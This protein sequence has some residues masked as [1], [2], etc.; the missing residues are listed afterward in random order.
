MKINADYREFKSIDDIVN[1]LTN[2]IACWPDDKIQD[3][4]DESIWAYIND[5]YYDYE[6]SEDEEKAVEAMAIDYFTEEEEE[7]ETLPEDYAERYELA[8]ILINSPAW[9][10]LKNPHDLATAYQLKE[11]KDAFGS[12]NEAEEEY[13]EEQYKD[14]FVANLCRI[15][16]EKGLSQTE[17][18]KEADVHIN[19][20]G[21]IERGER[22]ASK[23][24]LETAAKLAAAL[25]C[26]AEDLLD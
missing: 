6:L 19:V 21:R 8:E 11:L 15:R 22:S 3:A 17:L 16:R 14:A 18:A 24:S 9:D 5:W 10:G 4:V 26:H 13:Y 12:I 20:I 7:E 25:N 1:D 2:T 23:M